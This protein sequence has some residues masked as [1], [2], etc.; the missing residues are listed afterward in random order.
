MA[1]ARQLASE[2]WEIEGAPADLRLRDHR[3]ASLANRIARYH[4]EVDANGEIPGGEERWPGLAIMAQENEE[5]EYEYTH[6]EAMEYFAQH[7]PQL[8]QWQR[9]R[10][11]ADESWQCLTLLA[12]SWP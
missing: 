4:G 11:S 12:S 1:E 2:N 5:D 9:A 7:P 10:D 8:S 3:Q 6:R